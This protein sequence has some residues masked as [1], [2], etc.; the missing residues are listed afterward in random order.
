MKMPLMNAYMKAT[1]GN[2]QRGTHLAKILK[3]RDTSE[4][5]T[6]KRKIYTTAPPSRAQAE[7]LLRKRNSG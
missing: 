6:L 3:L 4:C 2:K 7:R 1:D 5:S